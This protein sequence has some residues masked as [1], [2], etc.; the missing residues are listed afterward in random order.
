MLSNSETSHR[1]RDRVRSRGSAVALMAILAASP[2][3][4][5][6][7]GAQ[8]VSTPAA[9]PA[10]S[11]GTPGPA[12]SNDAGAGPGATQEEQGSSE[13]L[14]G[15]TGGQNFQHAVASDGDAKVYTP[16]HVDTG[17]LVPVEIVNSGAERAFYKVDVR[18]Q[19]PDGFSATVHLSTDVVGVYPGGSWPAELTATD[20]GKP[21]P[22][23]PR[24]TITHVS[25]QE[26][27]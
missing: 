27:T 7:G 3:V 20:P 12:H 5:G 23:H 10:A 15:S 1:L 21:V 19:G 4:A 24:V 8:V 11:S 22:S 17:L 13:A 2:L 26:F 6:C 18:V 14:S 16:V 25:R 9:N